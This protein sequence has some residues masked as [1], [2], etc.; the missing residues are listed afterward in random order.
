MRLATLP[1]GSRD[2]WL[3]VVSRDLKSAAP[4][5]KL[6]KTMQEALDNW[7][8]VHGDLQGLYDALNDGKAAGAFPFDSKGALAPL[9]RAYQWLDASAFPSHGALMAKAFG[10]TPPLSDRPLMYQGMSHRFLS[11]TEAVSFP[12]EADGIDFE[13]EFGVVVDDVPMGV[14]PEAALGHIKLIVQINDWSLRTIAP[15]EMKTGFGWIRAKPAC[16]LAPVAVTP[17]ELGDAWRDGRVC[18][19]LVVD[20][21][22]KRFGQANGREMEVGFHE[23]IAHAASTRDLCAGTLIGSGTVSN[24]DHA[25]V[26]SSC[27]AEVRGAEILAT[28]AP[29]TSFMTFGSRVRMEARTLTDE[30]LFGPIDQQVVA[31]N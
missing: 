24:A 17:D 30:T 19:P 20:W 3:V 22:G 4:A 21:D 31:A 16:S 10:I 23:L 14:T 1:D 6:A 8:K 29:A 2:G 9:P 5:G 13:G 28:G 11:G 27:I 18:L 26:G 25:K 15:V 12:S 7:G